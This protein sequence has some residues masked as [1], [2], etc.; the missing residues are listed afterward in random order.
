MAAAAVHQ[1][2]FL[3]KPPFL[4]FLLCIGILRPTSRTAEIGLLTILVAGS[5]CRAGEP[6][7]RG[8][9]HIAQ[10]QKFAPQPGHDRWRFALAC[11]RRVSASTP[12]GW[13]IRNLITARHLYIHGTVQGVF[14]RGWAVDTARRLGLVGWVRNRRDGCVEALVQ[15]DAAAVERFIA[16]ALTGP[17]RATVERIEEAEAALDAN[18]ADFRQEATC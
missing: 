16:Q 8:L 4:V 1:A 11:E 3:S 15:G 12:G 7:R 14:Y 6:F 13:S 2:D 5:R 17:A 18:L 9:V 10:P